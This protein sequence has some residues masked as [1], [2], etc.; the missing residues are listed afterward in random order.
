MKLFVAWAAVMPHEDA[1]ALHLWYR[2]ATAVPLRLCDGDTQEDAPE[3]KHAA[4]CPT[5][6]AE[7]IQVYLTDQ[8]CGERRIKIPFD[9]QY[10]VA[11]K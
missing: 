7:C 10:P 5:V 1:P 11:T 8:A 9:Y 3:P 6:C 4:G 2:D